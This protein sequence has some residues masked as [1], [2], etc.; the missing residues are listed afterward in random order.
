MLRREKVVHTTK[1]GRK[2]K[3]MRGE[4]ENQDGDH[5]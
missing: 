4:E 5:Q 3:V 2:N 1:R